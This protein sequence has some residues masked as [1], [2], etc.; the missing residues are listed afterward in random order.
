MAGKQRGQ[1]LVSESNGSK[2]QGQIPSLRVRLADSGVVVAV[3]RAPR[4]GL[5]TWMRNNPRSD[6]RKALEAAMLEQGYALTD[7]HTILSK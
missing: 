5:L 4:S 2:V 1:F 6:E 3:I 7:V